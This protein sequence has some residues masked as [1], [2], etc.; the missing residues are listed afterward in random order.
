MKNKSLIAAS[1]AI[2]SAFLVL[3]IFA[4][5]W[6][7]IAE[8]KSYDMRLRYVADKTQADPNIVMITIDDA[9]IETFKRE[10][11]SWP[12]PRDFYGVVVD[13]VKQGGA[14]AVAFD[15]VFTDRDPKEADSS[16][17]TA[18]R[19]AGNVV[20]SS[21]M[22][23]DPNPSGT[24]IPPN[25]R[26]GLTDERGL[27]YP[28]FSTAVLP[29]PEFCQTAARIGNVNYY[30]DPQDGTC[31]RLPLISKIGKDY[32]PHVALATYLLIAG[33]KN[34]T[35][36]PNDMLKIGQKEIPI[37][38]K[39]NY[40]VWWYGTGGPG[41]TFKYYPISSII[42]SY[43]KALSGEEPLVKASEFKDKIVII[44][45]NAT[46]M[47]D[48]KNTPFATNEIPYPGM[49]IY[50]TILS[51]F[52][53][54]HFVTRASALIPILLVLLFAA[55]IAFPFI[56]GIKII[57]CALIFIVLAAVLL[58]AAV[59]LFSTAKIWI[60]VV[61][62][63]A[64]LVIAFLSSAVVSYQIESKQRKQLRNTFSRY[65]SPVVIREVLEK[66]DQISLGGREII[67]SVSFSDLKDFTNISESM[68]A[69][70]LVA[71]LNE[72]F[73]HATTQILQS[74]GMVDKYIGDAIMAVYGAPLDRTDHAIQA[75]NAAIDVQRVVA[76]NW[77]KGP[78]K[79]PTL[80][81]RIGINT[82]PMV[83][84]NIGS[85]HRLD[86]TAIG[87]T[88]NLASRLEGVNKIYST[89]IITTQATLDA[90]DGKFVARELDYLAVKGK[91]KP[92]SI[93]E[94][95]GKKDEVPAEM[96]RR[97]KLFEDGLKLYRNNEF[98]K[99]KEAF[100]ELLYQW[101]DD[102]PAAVFSDRCELFGTHPPPA[103]WGGVFR[104]TTK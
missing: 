8:L 44:G 50:A 100:D 90:T 41:G 14:K 99:A 5:G 94:L 33:E 32:I 34:V 4:L 21:N 77:N 1:I 51:N 37:D 66:T 69:S 49:E 27:E 30:D 87:D 9:S 18:M 56:R 42:V 102:G 67:G 59:F 28:V 39:G 23:K 61:P 58:G 10:E 96:I 103:D 85:I 25:A 17:A 3:L 73:T 15:I 88:V 92:A 95:I 86:Y 62:P 74:G 26:I 19:R 36:T 2:G 65:L 81:T 80:L 13:Y 29:L 45:S 71:M 22:T 53:Q 16:F 11:V 64:A 70:D 48:F 98:K 47:S 93:Y 76:K 84:G 63:I 43:G 91:D 97:I 35:V 46:A 104:L 83:V 52:N 75:C 38:N 78:R 7:E 72:Y 57:W 68:T 40:L 20:L 89:L 6:F 12:W 101:K 79:W 54:N 55:A 60:D 31:R 82:G 24:K